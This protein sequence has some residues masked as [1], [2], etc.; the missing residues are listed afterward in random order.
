MKHTSVF[1]LF[2]LFA[3]GATAATPVA[4]T[5]GDNLTAYNPTSGAISNA[6]WNNYANPRQGS[7]SNPAP[8]AD[9]GN[10]NAVILRCAQPK[11]A[12]GG[13]ASMDVARAI[14]SGCVESN[15]TCKEYGDDLVNYIS[16]Q[17]VASSTAAAN[18]AQAD[19]QIAVANAA[20]QQSSQQMAA[21][22]Q[23][24]QQMQ[25]QMA[26]QSADAAAQIQAALTQVQAQA[27]ANTTASAPAAT[28]GT[29][30]TATTASSGTGAVDLT[31]A[32]Q[33]AA[34]SGMDANLLARQQIAGQIL[35]QIENAETQ[36]RATK[37]AMDTAFDYA[38]CDSTGSNCT[39]PKRVEVFKDKAMEFFDPY[40]NVL[41]EL[42][43]ALILAQSVGVDITDIYMMLNGTCSVWGQY[44]C[45][46]GQVMH[47]T[48]KNCVNGRSRPVLS[49]GGV[50]F[51]NQP[52]TPGHVVPMSD[53]GCQPIRTLTS[54]DEVQ[55]NWLY[56]AS[57]TDGAQVRVGCMSEALENSSLFRNMNRQADIDIDVL[58]RIIEQDAPSFYGTSRLG[59]N[60][61]PEK[62]GLK[63]CAVG[64]KSYEELQRVAMLRDLPDQ[65]CVSDADLDSIFRND[66]QM[67]PAESSDDMSVDMI[68]SGLRGAEYD[69]CRCEH[70][71]DRRA[72]W[73]AEKGM[74]VCPDGTYNTWD[75]DRA[76][77]VNEKQQSRADV[78]AT[79]ARE[80]WEQEYQDACENAGGTW[81]TSTCNCSALDDE[82]E[83]K[84]C[85]AVNDEYRD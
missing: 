50:V 56:P 73:N 30:T 36:L 4:T 65:V 79:E 78:A 18:A 2:A 62:D 15:T 22:Q 59:G 47:Y 35:T 24:M 57:G 58:Q 10:C 49:G 45:A 76:D 55:A 8:T 61:T 29:A 38:G 85:S 17:L 6:I 52:C 81:G 60:T 39:G 20:A 26:Q 75:W 27:H 71:N 64:S 7:M 69:K 13:C 23:Q 19:A 1:L 53:G 21:M 12:N 67:I 33:V 84:K 11:C 31:T 72:S 63:Y 68:C 66:G 28:T 48:T 83:Y 82:D 25:Q 5:L 74:C 41:S 70:G 3:T 9:F 77:C 51:G 37:A 34:S 46:E 54:E 80:K 42:Y 32:Q 16:A 43:D 40:R 44:L 14:V